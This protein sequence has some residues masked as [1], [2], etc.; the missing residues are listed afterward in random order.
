MR[1]RVSKWTSAVIH[2]E[3]RLGKAGFEFHVWRKRRGKLGT[4]KVTAG[5]LSWRPVNGNPR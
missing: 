1:G 2:E 4:L 3:V 5:A